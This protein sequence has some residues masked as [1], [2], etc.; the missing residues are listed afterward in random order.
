MNS[1]F[2]YIQA[3]IHISVGVNYVLVSVMCWRH[4]CWRQLCVGVTYVLASHM[5]CRQ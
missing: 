5:C 3:I 1:M 2:N 4:M